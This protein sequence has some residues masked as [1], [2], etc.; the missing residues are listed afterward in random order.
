MYRTS[1]SHEEGGEREF[2]V[3][4]K[5]FLGSEGRVT[6]L[7]AVRVRFEEPGELGNIAADTSLPL[8]G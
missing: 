6:G 5:R 3:L 2:S 8:P 1:S 4:T 7:R